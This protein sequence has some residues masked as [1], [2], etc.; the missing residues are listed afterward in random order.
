MKARYSWQ[1]VVIVVVLLA[2][3]VLLYVLANQ[4]EAAMGAMTLALALVT[5]APMHVRDGSSK[6]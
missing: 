4:A 5:G 6:P 3:A 2:A 1:T